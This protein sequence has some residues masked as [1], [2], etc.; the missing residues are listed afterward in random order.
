[1]SFVNQ[2]PSG[3]HPNNDPYESGFQ[4]LAV[5]YNEGPIVV[6][7][8]QPTDI[9]VTGPLILGPNA[10]ILVIASCI[11]NVGAGT[12]SINAAIGIHRPDG[13]GGST[14]TNLTAENVLAGQTFKTIHRMFM[15]QPG[16][17]WPNATYRMGITQV[18]ATANGNAY[19]VGISVFGKPL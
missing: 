4:L 2:D 15:H 8:N 14:P 11:I 5:A 1:M 19:G 16:Q 3:Q 17:A 6:N 13:S 9:S 7:T 10:I 12:T 18:G